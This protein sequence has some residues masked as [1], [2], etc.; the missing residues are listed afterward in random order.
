MT[1]RQLEYVLVIARC[2]SI[3]LAAKELFI[4][5]QALSESLKL[6][7]QELHFTIFERSK[8]GVSLT[9]E[10]KLLIKDIEKIISCVRNWDNLAK[11]QNGFK[12][13]VIYVQNL[14]RD[15]III[16][17][18]KESIEMRGKLKIRWETN[19]IPQIMKKL[20]SNEPCIAILNFSP[21][22]YIYPKIM[23]LKA[24]NKC[25]IRCIVPEEEAKMQLIFRNGDKIAE[26]EKISLN[27][28]KEKKVVVNKGVEKTFALTQ[29]VNASDNAAIVLPS[30]ANAVDF[31]L[32]RDGYFTCLP[33]YIA[34]HNIHVINGNVCVKKILEEIDKGNRCWLLSNENTDEEIDI[35]A[36][37]MAKYILE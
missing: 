35:I 19:S 8:K 1:I 32:Q 29:I 20:S 33:D 12:P 2:N 17:D 5:Q 7:E 30:S 10:G 26:K 9:H 3:S 37:E 22:S 25:S 28:L 24:L 34:R 6:L 23:N 27:D 11:M 13:I 36:D 18:L 31:I 15:L 16:N 14:L 4:S 21:Q